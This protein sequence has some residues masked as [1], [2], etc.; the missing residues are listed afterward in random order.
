VSGELVCGLKINCIGRKLI[1]PIFSAIVL[2][3]LFN[4][5]ISYETNLVSLDENLAN[6]LDLLNIVESR[7]GLEYAHKGVTGSE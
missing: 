5:E 7:S 1:F 3:S 6:V 2:V 4:L